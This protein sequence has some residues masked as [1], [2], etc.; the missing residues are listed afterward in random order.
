[1]ESTMPPGGI[2]FEPF[3]MKTE[4]HNELFRELLD[5][6]H[7]HNKIK[8]WGGGVS[9]GGGWGGCLSLSKN[10]LTQLSFCNFFFHAK[11]MRPIC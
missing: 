8:K 10:N 11:I 4:K 6:S 5:F 3:F 1:M 7:T 2:G 9:G